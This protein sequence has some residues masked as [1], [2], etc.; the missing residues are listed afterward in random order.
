MPIIRDKSI[1]LFRIFVLFTISLV[2]AYWLSDLPGH[3]FKDRDNYLIYAT[4]AGDRLSY[5]WSEKTLL[6]YEPIFLIVNNILLVFNNPELTIKI[7][8]SQFVFMFLNTVI[9]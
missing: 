4:N 2:Y 9:I 6:F 3:L 5:L 7:I 8:V 1:D